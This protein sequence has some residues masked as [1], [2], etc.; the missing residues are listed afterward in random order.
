MSKRM[1]INYLLIVLIVIFTWIG[2][3]F[4]ISED[5]MIDRDAITTLKPKNINHIKIETADATIEL[6]KQGSTWQI[7][8][9]I[10]WFANNVAA[11]RLASLAAVHPQSKLPRTEIDISTLGLRIP[12]AVVTLN[13]KAVYFGNTNRIGNR[14]YL[15]VDPNVFLASDVYY[16]FISQGLIGLVDERLLPSH[17][18]LKSLTLSAAKIEKD[19]NGWHSESNENRKQ[20]EQL[21]TNWQRTAATRI[22][23]FNNNATPLQKLKATLQDDSEINFYLLTIKPEIIIARPDLKLAYHFPEHEYY[24][25]L[26]LEKPH[27]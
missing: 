12:R 18:A 21:V 23:A 7:D 2:I 3:K 14:R 26:A 9:P 19:A 15:M 24:N 4:P 20:A 1:L 16:P 11:E 6:N 13:D 25:L 10:H 17:L 27:E 8:Q 22:T 5:Q